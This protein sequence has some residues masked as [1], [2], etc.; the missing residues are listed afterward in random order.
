M[1]SFLDITGQP[2]IKP[3]PIVSADGL[4]R[5]GTSASF[6]TDVIE[7]S[8]QVP[9][10]VDFW[11]TWCG[12]CVQLTP[13]LE[14]VV[15][16]QNGKIKLVKIDVD[17]NQDVATQLRIQSM[18]TVYAFF[19]GQPVDAFQGMLPES[20]LNAF[21]ERLLKTTGAVGGVAEGD[22]AGA[23]F[24]QAGEALAK[25][26]YEL[27]AQLYHEVLMLETGH[28]GALIGL[29][30]VQLATGDVAGARLSLGTLPDAAKTDKACEKE[31]AA[32]IAA[33]DLATKAEAAGPL[34]DLEAKVAV[35]PADH[36]ARYDLAVALYAA[37]RTEQ[38]ADE[39]LN[40]IAADR[41][42]NDE[43]AKKQLLT[44][45]EALGSADSVV[46]TARRRLSSLLFS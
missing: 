2:A 10:L 6:M 45:F 28:A 17:Q 34:G 36:Q 20:Q 18:P 43:A 38:A 35:S 25:G 30:R 33:L 21:I 15:I 22:D 39:L 44:M 13:L 9:V 8:L 11:A 12:P 3:E 14:K 37:G 26:Y 19:Q 7:A 31:F 24:A 4:I 46:R 41:A 29:V 5:D 27:A 16:A 23:A 42:W 40:I 32:L 1:N